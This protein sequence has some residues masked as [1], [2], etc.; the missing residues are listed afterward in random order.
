MRDP[1]LPPLPY[2]VR[3]ALQLAFLMNSDAVSEEEKSAVHRLEAHDPSTLEKPQDLMQ[4]E[5]TIASASDLLARVDPDHPELSRIPRYVGQI[6]RNS[7]TLITPTLDPIGVAT[8]PIAC[9]ANHSCEPNASVLFDATRLMM[10]SLAPIKKGEEVFISYVDNTD[11]FYRRQALLRLRYRFECKC[12]KCQLRIN[13]K[14]NAWAKSLSNLAPKWSSFAKVMDEHE[15]YSAEPA[16]YLGES[17]A[18]M[19][20][21][22]IQGSV[23]HEYEPIRQQKDNKLAIEALENVMRTCKQ[24]ELWPI[25]RQPYANIRVDIAARMLDENRVALALFQMAK[26]YFLIDPILYPQDFHPVRVV[27]IWNLAKTLVQAYSSPN[28]PSQTVDPGVEQLFQRGFD[29]VVPV[30]KLLKKLSVDVVKSHGAESRLTFMVHT[31]TEQVKDGVGLQNLVQ[32]ERDPLATRIVGL[33]NISPP[34]IAST[35]MPKKK[36]VEH[37]ASAE[38]NTKDRS[39]S[40]ASS[41]RRIVS[42]DHVDEDARTKRAMKRAASKAKTTNSHQQ[43]VSLLDLPLEILFMIFDQAACRDHLEDRYYTIQVVSEGDLRNNLIIHQPALLMVCSAL[44]TGL[45]SYFYSTCP[46][47]VKI[48]MRSMMSSTGE[49]LTL[50]QLKDRLSLLYELSYDKKLTIEVQEL[51]KEGFDFSVLVQ[52]AAM[53]Y[54]ETLAKRGGLKLKD[55][56]WWLKC[57]D[58]LL[59]CKCVRNIVDTYLVWLLDDIHDKAVTAAVDISETFQ[60]FSSQLR[61][62]L[63]EEFDQKNRTYWIRE[64]LRDCMSATDMYDRVDVLDHYYEACECVHSDEMDD[65][66]DDEDGDGEEEDEG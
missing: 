32:I 4:Y 54:E 27:H 40:T 38:H 5:M 16:N 42:S 9:S 28:D 34:A 24:S 26:T 29:F 60:K 21:A 12:S 47:H 36:K 6:L 11:P 22:I 31:L 49:A 61:R 20:M 55:F 25:T 63:E 56:D 30:W 1:D 41:S 19:D 43:T 52:I 15:N 23:Y 65:D 7:L 48:Q 14:E 39:A 33:V 57:T 10:R 3:A 18:E 51:S 59:Q 62:W 17:R 58:P 44:R 45:S 66:E 46:F 50:R 13:G 35:T 53:L 64:T 37:Q 2:S 8:D